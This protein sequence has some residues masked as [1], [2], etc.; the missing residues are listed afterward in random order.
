MVSLEN[1]GSQ[2]V[3]EDLPTSFNTIR[4][5]PTGIFKYV[6][7]PSNSNFSQINNANLSSTEHQSEMNEQIHIGGNKTCAFRRYLCEVMHD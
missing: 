7:L 2:C 4:A 6:P 3:R 1:R 5:Y